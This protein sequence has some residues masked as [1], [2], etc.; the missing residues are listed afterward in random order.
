[1]Y[2]LDSLLPML[3]YSY[4]YDTDGSTDQRQNSME[5]ECDGHLKGN[6]SSHI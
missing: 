3:S 5:E 1:M 2:L 6:G 4:Y